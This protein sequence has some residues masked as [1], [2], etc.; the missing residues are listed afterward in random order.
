MASGDL[1][2]AKRLLVGLHERLWHTPVMDFTNL[3]RRAG[4]PQEVLAL[5]SEAVA[6]CVV[7]RKFV[8]LPNRPQVR[9][10]G[11]TVFNDT[12]QLDL[13]VL[14]GTTYLLILDEATRFKTCSVPEG[15]ESEQLLKSLF[16][17]WIQMF[18]PPARVVLDQQASLMGHETGLSI[19]RCPR[20]TTQGHGAD[21]H[22]G[23]G[24]VERHVELMKLTI[25]KLRAELQRQGLHPEP[26]ELGQ[27]S[28]MAHNQTIN[29]GGATPCMSVLGVLP[30]GFYDPESAGVMSTHGA[31]QR[32]LSTFER[33]LRIRQTALAQTQQSIIEDRVARANRHRPHQLNLDKMVAGVTEVEYYR[34]VAGDPGWRGP[35]LL[36]R[37]DQTA[38]Q[39]SCSTRANHTW[40][41]SGSS[42]PTRASTTSS[43]PVQQQNKI[44]AT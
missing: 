3:L 38:A 18:G 35:A 40:L 43:E 37:I 28:A 23:T 33:A 22:T 19:M 8:R 10:G 24:L 29:Y 6:G 13:F 26:E 34:E 25:Q 30:R 20:G 16:T 39:Q 42:D 7:C 32:D 4:Q 17:S 14:D 27:E 21:Q 44:Y 9:A 2:V 12:I 41:H 11:A 5:A 15:Q 1:A 36:L 31:L